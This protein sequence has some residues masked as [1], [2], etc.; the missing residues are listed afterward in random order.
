M[1]GGQTITTEHCAGLVMVRPI[2]ALDD[3]EIGLCHPWWSADQV[4]PP[5]ASAKSVIA[6]PAFSCAR[7]IHSA[8]LQ[9][10]LLAALTVIQAIWWHTSACECFA[11]TEEVNPE[12]SRSLSFA[13]AAEESCGSQPGATRQKPSRKWLHEWQWNSAALPGDVNSM[14]RG[15]TSQV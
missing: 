11:R 7:F 15:C 14:L 1:A 12:Q 6:V 5:V 3:E 9:P 8:A 2:G 4:G 10:P 13:L